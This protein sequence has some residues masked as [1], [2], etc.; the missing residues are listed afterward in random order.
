MGLWSAG[1]INHVTPTVINAVC[2]QAVADH[3]GSEEFVGAIRAP[4]EV[5]VNELVELPAEGESDS[6]FDRCSHALWSGERFTIHGYTYCIAQY[7]GSGWRISRVIDNPELP[8]VPEK[9]GEVELAGILTAA[10]GPHPNP[11]VARIEVTY[12]KVARAGYGI[13]KDGSFDIWYD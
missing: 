9:I 2:T 7:Y 1:K 5:E 8:Y 6:A 3:V 12:A 13:R 11:Y 4:H 10:N